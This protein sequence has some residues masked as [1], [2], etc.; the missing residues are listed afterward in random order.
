MAIITLTSDM[1]LKDHYVSA[2]KGSILTQHPEAD[3]VDISH[4]IEKY[5]IAQAA[6]ILSHAWKEFPEG[7]IHIIGIRAEATDHAPHVVMT[8]NGHYFI[9]ADNGFFSLLFDDEPDGVFRLDIHLDNDVLT[10]PTKDVFVKTACHIARGGTPEVI[11]RSVK[12][13]NRTHRFDALAEDHQIKGSV[14]YVDS[15]GNA[16]TNITKTLFEQVG[17]GREFT[18][19]TKVSG[20]DIQTLNKN[21]NEV[22]EGERLALFG[23]G[24]HLEVAMNVGN[25]NQLMGLSVND[26]VR[27]EFRES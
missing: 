17:R 3:I 19:S 6:Y 8:K 1:G 26:V 18:I 13:Y 12:D 21:Y 27:V 9:G 22:I 25:A 14:I 20:Y 15:Y 4:D 5:N 23:S 24:G 16:I 7:S 11:G 10:F 2:V